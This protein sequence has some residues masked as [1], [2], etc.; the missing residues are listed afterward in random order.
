MLQTAVVA[1][2]DRARLQEIV[3]VLLRFG[4]ADLVDTL[5]LA[6]FAPRGSQP[7]PEHPLDASRPERLRMALEHLGPSFVKLGQIMATRS[8]LL[9]PEWTAALQQLH[10]HAAPLPWE[11]AQPLIEQSLGL[12]VE[13]VF[14]H[15]DPVPLAS[16]SMAQ[17]YRARLP[18]AEDRDDRDDRE[19]QKDGRDSDSTPAASAA[20]IEV[21]VK[22]QRPG[23]RP[24]IEADLRLLEH[25]ALLAQEQWPQLARYRP[26][27]VTRQ[28]GQALRE[29]LDFTVEAH[30]GDAVARH[31]AA[32]PEIVVPAIHWALSGPRLLVQDFVPGV[33]ASAVGAD[34]ALDGPLLAR[35]GAC[36]FLQMVLRDGLFHADPHPGNL[37]AL[38]G[39][40]VGFIDFGMV[41]RL[42][43]QRRR[44]VLGLMRALVEGQGRSLSGVLLEWAAESEMPGRAPPS[45]ARI[46]A[47]VDR[48]VTR[49][50][51]GA[52]NGRL[53]M[54]RA[55]QDF[56]A[57]AR[58]TGVALPADMALLLKA[59]ITA[60][61]VL[62]QLDPQFDVVQTATPL[63]KAQLL[64]RYSLR[65]LARQR[66]AAMAQW[67]ELAD[68]APHT[69]RLVMQR[70]R[71]GRLQADLD[72]RHIDRLSLA[73]E[74][75]ATRLALAVVSGAFILGL[76]P[77]L[78]TMGPRL[79]GIPLFAALG[80][81]GAAA[82][83]AVL[84]TTMRRQKALD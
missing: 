42:S 55:L 25:L 11:T 40:R 6:R 43:P 61:Q 74:R 39:N 54:S 68:D 47:A 41:G 36:A 79:W 76:A 7:H 69:L 3:G 44:Q 35:R 82:S 15:F 56:M 60:D 29:E 83:L 52:S 33:P 65:S 57:L 9:A 62:L 66:R 34:P 63:V 51:P 28:L 5:G 10:S 4:L 81:A 2:R 84:F 14:A 67:M 46:E 17:V 32:Q 21:V 31:F 53:V 20:D 71:S 19:D 59:L 49:H 26:R 12:P 78:L 8:D 27:E 22:V 38:P 50:G 30:N 58:E 73:L 23:L 80:V 75:A 18:A 72:I 16:A 64:Q 37:L 1:V 48:F 70:L 13:Q 24:Q 77:G 45:A